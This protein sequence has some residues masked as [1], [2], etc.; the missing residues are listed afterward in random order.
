MRIAVASGKGGTGKTTLAVNL[1]LSLDGEVCLADCD[2]E[3]PNDHLFIQ[4]PV[5]GEK[6]V[7]VQIPVINE[8]RCTACGRCADVCEFNAL[9]VIGG[10]VLV[11][12][13]LCHG[14]GGCSR[15]CPEKAITEREREIGTVLWGRRENLHFI[16]GRLNIG[17][18]LAPPVIRAVQHRIPKTGTIIIDSPPGTT[19]SMV[20]AVADSDYCILVAENTPFGLHDAK[21]AIQA[22]AN[23]DVPLGVVINRYDTGASGLEAFLES[24]KIPVLMR[25]PFNEEIARLYSRGIPF[26]TELT[27]Y[28]RKLIDLAKQVGKEVSVSR[29]GR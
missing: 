12:E 13:Q 20:Q 18:A 24:E 1:A 22:V 29:G 27:E 11:F 2:V 5:E 14:C 15:F 28:R 3:E 17:E 16:Y 8:E 26:V 19:C 25:I 9:A 23:L 6:A 7:H 21:I 4:V 10:Q